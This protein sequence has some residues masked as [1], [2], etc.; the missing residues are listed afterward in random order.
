MI[1]KATPAS[2]M[3]ESVKNKSYDGLMMVRTN[4]AMMQTM[5]KIPH[6]ILHRSH[7]TDPF[8]N[9]FSLA[10]F[11]QFGRYRRGQQQFSYC[12]RCFCD[13]V[14]NCH[15]PFGRGLLL[16][17]VV[18]FNHPSEDACL[19]SPPE[20]LL[21]ASAFAAVSFPVSILVLADK[22]GLHRQSH[23]VLLAVLVY[24]LD[25]RLVGQ[26]LAG[27]AVNEAIEP[28]Q[29]V[30]LHVAFVQAGRQIHRRS[31]RDV[32]C[33]CDDRRHRCRAS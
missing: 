10:F 27:N 19:H 16:G 8:S 6:Q 2:G 31:G 32:S 24:S 29:G 9:W 33:W 28:R 30:V 21:D 22:P 25:Q 5:T 23:R 20:R 15:A 3:A 7:D 18:I 4:S 17:I 13:L 14:V 12:L 1:P 11:V 26:P